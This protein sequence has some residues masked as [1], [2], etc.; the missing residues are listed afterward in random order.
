MNILKGAVLIPNLEYVFA[1]Q[2]LKIGLTFHS[3]GVAKPQFVL[4]QGLYINRL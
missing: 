4:R 1:R 2:V 3:I